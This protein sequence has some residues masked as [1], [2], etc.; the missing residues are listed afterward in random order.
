[1]WNM[2]AWVCTCW[3]RVYNC[4][5]DICVFLYMSMYSMHVQVFTYFMHMFLYE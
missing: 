4:D 1:M 2:H 5:I 3:M